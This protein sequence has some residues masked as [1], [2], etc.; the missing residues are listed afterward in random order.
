MKNV[1]AENIAN[2]SNMNR[3]HK[4]NRGQTSNAYVGKTKTSKMS[5]ESQKRAMS[6]P[7]ST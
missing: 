4:S 7:W 1:Q 3:C 2:F 6:L 5:Q